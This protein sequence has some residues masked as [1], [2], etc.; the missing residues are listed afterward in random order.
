MGIARYSGT[1]VDELR[2]KAVCRSRI[3]LRSSE[4][5]SLH[6]AISASKRCT[7]LHVSLCFSKYHCGTLHS[8]MRHSIGAVLIGRA[9][10]K[11]VTGSSA[12]RSPKPT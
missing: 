7:S 11:G 8:Q 5:D 4:I 3:V 9:N 1:V 10:G 6:S 2:S 12:L